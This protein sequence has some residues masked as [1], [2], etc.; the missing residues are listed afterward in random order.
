MWPEYAQRRR[1]TSAGILDSSPR[2]SPRRTRRR[3]TILWDV[4]PALHSRFSLTPGYYL[5]PF[6]GFDS[7]SQKIVSWICPSRS[8]GAVG[9]CHLPKIETVPDSNARFSDHSTLSVA[10]RFLILPPTAK[11]R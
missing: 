1:A 6:Q 5:S 3:R 7:A 10:G 8:L 2:P 11:P 4:Y 9:I